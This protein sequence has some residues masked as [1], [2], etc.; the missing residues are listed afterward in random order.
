MRR[1]MRGPSPDQVLC[2]QGTDNGFEFGWAFVFNRPGMYT[3]VHAALMCTEN[4]CWGGEL[5]GCKTHHGVQPALHKL[6]NRALRVCD[7]KGKLWSVY[8]WVQCHCHFSFVQS[9]YSDAA[10]L[11]IS[12]FHGFCERVIPVLLPFPWTTSTWISALIPTHYLI[13]T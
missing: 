13:C 10:T 3:S 6:E 4:I 9:C 2:R 8:H 1:I 7:A 5:Q 12:T 11:T